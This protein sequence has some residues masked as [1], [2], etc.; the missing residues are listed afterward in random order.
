M[1][2]LV[3]AVLV[4]V[5]GDLVGVPGV[6]VGVL[7]VLVDVPG[8]SFGIFDVFGIGMVYLL[9]LVLGMVSLAVS[10]KKGLCIFFKNS[11]LTLQKAVYFH[12]LYAKKYAGLKKYT[13]AG[14]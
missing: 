6:S 13:T 10:S 9:H 7:G 3:F 8:V 1:F 2:C 11:E 5:H 14:D 12:I 4:G